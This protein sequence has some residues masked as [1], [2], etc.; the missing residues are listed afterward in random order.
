CMTSCSQE[1][2]P[3]KQK[4]A[5]AV[6]SVTNW[7]MVVDSG[8]YSRSWNL[9]GSLFKKQVSDSNW[10]AALNKIRTPFGKIE[11]RKNSAADYRTSLPGVPDG[12]YVITA[13]R[14]SFY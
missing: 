13:F 10:T 8:N 5:E 6:K 9:A 2:S 1:T 7:L 4:E 11:T 3:N 12:E 14:T